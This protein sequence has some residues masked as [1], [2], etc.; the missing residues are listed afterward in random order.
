MDLTKYGFPAMWCKRPPSGYN[1]YD[2]FRD[3]PLEEKVK[4]LDALLA[5]GYAHYISRRTSGM[6][7]EYYMY[8][9][10]LPVPFFAEKGVIYKTGVVDHF[11]YF[12]S[13]E[14]LAKYGRDLVLKSRQGELPEGQKGLPGKTPE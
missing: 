7:I 11:Q 2:C 5:D 14:A 12:R 6:G 9:M 10:D 13:P 3:I 4:I 1:C 8:Y